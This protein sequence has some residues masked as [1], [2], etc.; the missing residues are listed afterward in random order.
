M[1]TVRNSFS[2]SAI[3]LAVCL[4]MLLLIIVQFTFH[5]GERLCRFT[6]MKNEKFEGV[7]KRQ[8]VEPTG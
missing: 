4:D 7:E 6:Y 5:E 2:K 3:A 8:W 1:Q